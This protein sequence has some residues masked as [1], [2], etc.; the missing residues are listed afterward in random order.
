MIK[1]TAVFVI[2]LIIITC[3]CDQVKHRIFERLD[4]D[5]TG[6]HFNNKIVEDDNHNVFNYMNIYTGAGVGVG[7]INND[8]L[9]DIY[10][11][12]NIINGQLYLNQGNFEFNE[13]TLESGIMNN[14]WETGVTMVDINQDGWTDIYVCVAGSAEGETR[15][16]LLYINQGDNTFVESAK[17]YGIAE[18]RKTMQ[19]TFF[20]YDRDGDLDLFMIVNS[21]AYEN[22]VN[23]IQPRKTNGE[24]HNTDILFRNNGDNTFT[25][26]SREAGILIEGYSLGVAISDINNDNWPDIYVSN[27]FIGN[28]IM[29][30]NNRD[31]TFTDQSDRRLNHTSYA[32]MGNDIADF[33]ND[34]LVDIMVLD[35]RPEDNKR[36]KLITSSTS[37]D[38]FQLMLNAGYSPQYSRNTLQLNRGNGTFSEIGF[39]AGV[40]ST[41][42]SWSSLF[43]DFDNDADK[44]LFIT[45]GFL[46]DLGDLDYIHY[47]RFNSGPMGTKEAKINKKLQAIKSLKGAAI[48]DYLYE[49][50]GNLKFSNQAKAW[51]INKPGYS[52]GAAY[53]DFDNDGDL[54]L[55]VN[56]INEKSHVYRNNTSNISSNNYLRIALEGSPK[57]R[58]GIGAKI[59]IRH[60]NGIQFTE[61]FVNRGYESSVD[62]ILH[63]GLGKDSLIRQLTIIWPDGKSEDRNDV[64]ANQLLKLSYSHAK[65]KKREG[66]VTFQKALI[67]ETKARNLTHKH[68]ENEFVDFKRQPILPHM[69]SRIG[70]GL[71]AGDING[72]GLD[73]VFVGG[74]S[75]KQ[76]KVLLQQSNGEFEHKWLAFDAVCEDMGTLFFDADGD[77]D[78]DLYV[79]SGGTFEEKNSPVYQD[80][81]YLNNG[82]GEF[83]KTNALPEITSSG[84]IITASDYD[85]DGDLDLFVGGRVIPGEYPLAPKSYLLQNV[86]TKEGVKFKDIT[87]EVGNLSTT[88]L[89][90]SALWSDYNGDGWTDLIV[91]GEFMPVKFYRNL[92]GNLQEDKN[93]GLSRIN[94]WW[95]SING[96]DFDHDGDIDYIVGNLGLNSR[97]V[98][99][100]AEPLCIYAKD[101]DKNGRLDPVMCYYID[102]ENYLGHT[103]DDMIDQIN[104]MRSRF[105][106]YKD[107]A[108]ATFSTSFM[109]SELEDAYVVKCHRF[110][111]S[112][113]NNLG[114]GKFEIKALPRELQMSPINGVVIYDLNQDGRLDVLL[115]GNAYANEVSTGRYDAGLGSVLLGNGDGSF[116]VKSVKESGFIADG[117]VKS[118]SKLTTAENKTLFLVARNSDSLK[119]YIAPSSKPQIIKAVNN[120]AFAEITFENGSVRR[121]EFYYGASYLSQSARFITVPKTAKKITITDFQGKKREYKLNWVSEKLEKP[122]FKDND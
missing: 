55:V 96:A 58:Q 40:S 68:Q 120:D 3:S 118:I 113:L 49:N 61:N 64:K 81:L 119:A 53:A 43:A 78:L 31:G 18:N 83:S 74:A 44:D 38:R 56:N 29:Y 13:I 26:V 37:Y 86:S 63:F 90:T 17:K 76:G 14:R 51:G 85:K 57:N 121:Q 72:D 105:M 94:G 36:Q 71:A 22:N 110:E 100:E 116:E 9:M 88:G 47:Q 27:D 24:S 84:S 52:N 108:N 70:P 114:E 28:D 46:R 122:E 39:L 69:H 42:W 21:A 77:D 62:P 6:I 102:G 67:D 104:A 15:N 73:D 19:A 65:Q 82:L 117:D 16:N 106:T 34:G 99:S 32:G 33:N 2:F 111:S 11:A 87:S 45:N 97:F 7:D 75:G 30:I 92:R 59:I 103:R 115:G 1:R 41:D 5:K 112:Y 93:T 50:E 98:A 95:N 80:R 91:T 101:Y 54:D 12:G 66:P 4:A 20:D 23:V 48:T 10:M 107:Y 89:V 8:G 109:A 25:D 79:V 35:M 60:G